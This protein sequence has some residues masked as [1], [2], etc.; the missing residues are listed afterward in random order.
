MVIVICHFIFF[1]FFIIFYNLFLFFI[2]YFKKYPPVN[3]TT[4][5]ISKSMFYIQF[6]LYIHYYIQFSS[7]FFFKLNNF[8]HLET[9]T[10]FNFYINVIMMF[11]LKFTFLLNILVQRYNYFNI[12]MKILRMRT[13]FKILDQRWC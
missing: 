4:C 1:C 11:L 6:G 10:K 7:N 2:F 8:V 12:R 13:N 3:P 5:H 9:E